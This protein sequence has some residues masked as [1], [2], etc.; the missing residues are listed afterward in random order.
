MSQLKVG[1]IALLSAIP[2]VILAL[3]EST[4]GSLQLLQARAIPVE[5]IISEILSQ[6]AEVNAAVDN[7]KSFNR[8]EKM[9][10]D[11]KR[12]AEAADALYTGQYLNRYEETAEKD[13]QDA[14][15]TNEALH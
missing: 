1:F 9:A 11:D 14:E 2:N 5:L 12:D 6:D 15:A 8:Y 3:P 7:N 4:L 13:K 10:V